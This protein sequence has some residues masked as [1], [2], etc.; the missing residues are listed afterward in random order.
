MFKAI[1]QKAKQVLFKFNSS[2]ACLSA[3]TVLTECWSNCR[4]LTLRA[5]S[6]SENA[7]ENDED[8]ESAMEEFLRK[9]AEKESGR[10]LCQSAS[11]HRMKLGSS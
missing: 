8:L 1:H 5:V 11:V 3:F 10:A 2:L 4:R 6:S 9:Q 7:V